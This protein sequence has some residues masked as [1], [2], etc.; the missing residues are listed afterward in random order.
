MKVFKTAAVSVMAIVL[1]TGCSK[2]TG[3]GPVVTENRNTPQFNRLGISVP[4][5]VVYTQSN[6]YKVEIEAQQNIIDI[7]QTPVTNGELIVKIKNDVRIKSHE[8]IIVRVSSPEMTGLRVSGSGN[9]R[10]SGNLQS[11]SM[12]LNISGSG[13]IMVPQLTTGDIEA[14][15]SGS[16]DIRVSAGSAI[17][18]DLRISGSGSIDLANVT[19]K[20][21]RTSTSGSGTMRVHA[22][23]RLEVSISG[24]GNVFYKGN[25]SITTSISGSGKVKPM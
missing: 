11:E 13:N 9:L 21:A 3:S 6:T 25:P 10:S 15:V 22:S 12:R 4:G 1:I 19:A 2:I 8:R 20:V 18:E 23:D 14:T 7:I 24:S 16:G 5:D 17:E